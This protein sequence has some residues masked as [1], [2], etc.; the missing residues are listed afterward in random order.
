MT[1]REVKFPSVW[2]TCNGG[3][4]S[5][6]LCARASSSHGTM[7]KVGIGWKPGRSLRASGQHTRVCLPVCRYVCV[8]VCMLCVLRTR[9]CQCNSRRWQLIDYSNITPRYLPSHLF[10]PCNLKRLTTPCWMLTLPKC[11]EIRF[12]SK[13]RTIQRTSLVSGQVCIQKEIRIA[14]KKISMKIYFCKHFWAAITELLK[15]E[16]QSQSFMLV[17]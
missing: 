5:V 15:S 10:Q 12:L 11:E 2:P 1:L 13:R 8:C 17:S 9:V 14:S 4:V 6:R 3:S 7:D 16:T